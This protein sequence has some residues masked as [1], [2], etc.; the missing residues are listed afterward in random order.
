MKIK[1]IYMTL[2]P[3]TMWDLKLI[4]FDENESIYMSLKF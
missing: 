1:F 2:K 4:S 3:L